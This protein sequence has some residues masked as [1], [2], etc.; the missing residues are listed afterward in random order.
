[1]RTGYNIIVKYH[2]PGAKEDKEVLAIDKMPRLS[3]METWDIE[4]P[5][6]VE[7]ISILI[8]DKK[9]KLFWKHSKQA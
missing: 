2:N 5:D 1:M 6:G 3:V 4:L 9:N 8:Y 7:T